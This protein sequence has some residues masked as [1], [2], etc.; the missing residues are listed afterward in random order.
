MA[1][2]KRVL[3]FDSKES[4]P[5]PPTSPASPWQT[6]AT[7]APD[8]DDVFAAFATAKRRRS[9]HAAWVWL[10]NIAVA[11]IVLAGIN[12]LV[13][14]PIRDLLSSEKK[15]PPAQVTLDLVAAGG[16]AA[17]FATDYLSY[18]GPDY[19]KH[20]HAA[21]AQ[22]VAPGEGTAVTTA[23]WSGEAVLR[24]DSPVVQSSRAVGEDAASIAVLVR[25]QA[26]TPTGGPS[27]TTATTS[28]PAPPTR[29]PPPRRCPRRRPPAHRRSCHQCRATTRPRPR[30]GYG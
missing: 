4:A 12:Q 22:W 11:L 23:T 21:L 27:P 20:R 30:C 28:V 17:G 5:A 29:P 26:Y 3:G 7:P 6:A 1:A 18:G 16:V 2:W 8:H 24:A 13:I 15:A 14:H 19:T 10:R 25:V 9:G